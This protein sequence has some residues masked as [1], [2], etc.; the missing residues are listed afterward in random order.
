MNNNYYYYLCFISFYFICSCSFGGCASSRSG[1]QEAH[2]EALERSAL[3][4]RHQM[5]GNFLPN[6]SIYVHFPLQEQQRQQQQQ[7]QWQ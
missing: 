1:G 5:H 7:W 4:F 3:L 2:P 6:G